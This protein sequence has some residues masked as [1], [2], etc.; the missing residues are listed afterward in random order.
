VTFRL[1]DEPAA[2]TVARLGASGFVVSERSGWVRAA[3]HATTSFEAIDDLVEAL[4]AR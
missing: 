1:P 3:P 2:A 4:A